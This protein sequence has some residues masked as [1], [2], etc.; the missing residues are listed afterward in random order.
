MNVPEWLL[1]TWEKRV[2]AIEKMW[3]SMWV[4][5]STDELKAAARARHRADKFRRYHERG[6]LRR[7][8]R[9]MAKRSRR[10]NA[11]RH[12]KSGRAA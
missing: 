2:E 6:D 11:G 9:R 10:I 12:P 3:A 1:T 8:R 4:T 5:R 7:Q